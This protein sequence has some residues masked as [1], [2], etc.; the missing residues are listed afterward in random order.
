MSETCMEVSWSWKWRETCIRW[1]LILW[2][3]KQLFT[4]P[5]QKHHVQLLILTNFSQFSMFPLSLRF[6]R[7]YDEWKWVCGKNHG[8]EKKVHHDNEKEQQHLRWIYVY[9]FT[10]GMRRRCST[11]IKRIIHCACI[12]VI[13]C[14]MKGVDDVRRRIYIY[15]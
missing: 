11:N 10:N 12:H 8:A 13:C 14:E 15:K 4:S 3:K 5:W 2:V 9:F 7:I 6:T 1:H